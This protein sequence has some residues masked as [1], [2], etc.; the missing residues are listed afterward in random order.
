MLILVV[1]QYTVL[2]LRTSVETAVERSH[3]SVGS[4][5]EVITHLAR[6][7]SVRDL[8]DEVSKRCPPGTLFNGCTFSSGHREFLLQLLRS[9][10]VS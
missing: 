10:L 7:L 3:D 9:T 5:G 6:A 4:G 1:Q 8:H 2:F